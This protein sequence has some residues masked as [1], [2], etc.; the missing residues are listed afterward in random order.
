MIDVLCGV[1][2]GGAFQHHLKSMYAA[3]EEP[4]ETC[5]LMIAID[6]SVHLG[7]ELFLDRMD[8]LYRTIKASPTWDSEARMLLPGELENETSREATQGRH[9]FAAQPPG[10][11]RC[12]GRSS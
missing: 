3:P 12:L 2:S 10:E 7:R 6:P 5:H 11:A 4:S 8:E 1:L 9:P